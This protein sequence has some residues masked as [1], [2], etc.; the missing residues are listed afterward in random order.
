M[1]IVYW[2]GGNFLLQMVEL[3]N[4]LVKSHGIFKHFYSRFVN[5]TLHKSYK[6]ERTS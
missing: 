6:G 4:F 3:K 5:L 1:L 2:V